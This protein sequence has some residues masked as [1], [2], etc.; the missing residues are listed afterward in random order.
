MAL[1]PTVPAPAE[2][3]LILIAELSEEAERHPPAIG[4]RT[5]LVQHYLSIG[6]SE[7]AA[8]LVRELQRVAPTNE[9]VLRLVEVV[10]KVRYSV[11][12]TPVHSI[13]TI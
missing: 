10:E 7:A 12:Q 13:C 1:S 2:P 11:H 3:D 5:L 4:A 9:E 6:W 8:E